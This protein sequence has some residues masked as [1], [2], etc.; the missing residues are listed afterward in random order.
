MNG[1]QLRTL[2]VAAGFV[3]GLPPAISDDAAQASSVCPDFFAPTSAGASP[4]TDHNGNGLICMRVHAIC[5][6]PG[7]ACR[8]HV[9]FV[10]DKIG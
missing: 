4:E 7:S 3:L 8:K 1:K 10:D 2:L 5:G 6:S 9:I